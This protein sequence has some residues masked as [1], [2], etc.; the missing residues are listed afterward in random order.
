MN[1]IKVEQ[2]FYS[3]HRS[4]IL[5]LFL[6]VPL[7]LLVWSWDMTFNDRGLLPSLG[8]ASLFLPLY[9]LIFEMPHI[10]ASF[11]GFMDK[12]YVAHY[13]THLMVG[14]PLMLTGFFSLL[15]FDITT[16]VAVYLAVTMY[17]VMRQQT[18]IALMFGVPKNKWHER[19]AWSLVLSTAVMY[20]AI[21]LPRFVEDINTSYLVFFIVAT[22]IA[23]LISG[24][25]LARTTSSRWGISYIALTLLMVITSYTVLWFGY[26]FLAIFVARFIH[27]VTAFLFYI[28]HEMNRNKDLVRNFLYQ[29]I[30]LLPLSLILVVPLIAIFL[31]VF[32]R[33][34]ISNTELLFALI[35]TFGFIHYYLESVMWKRGSPHREFVKVV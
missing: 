27:D 1:N 35:M 23:A 7:V 14:I 31:G 12:E 11:V 34:S 5:G 20:V 9:L 10:F 33:E 25:F 32:L 26:F 18:G 21:M 28:T 3:I 29:A 13:R 16:A 6:I 4:W 24:G 2:T 15:W 22:L 30:P 8:P 19:W 17:H